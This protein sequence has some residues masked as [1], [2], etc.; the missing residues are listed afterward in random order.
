MVRG[1]RN[2]SRAKEMNQRDLAPVKTLPEHAPEGLG[3][4]S[5]TAIVRGPS[6]VAQLA[7][8]SPVKRFVASSSL[9]P[10]AMGLVTIPILPSPDFDATASF[11]ATLGFV[12]LS[13]GGRRS[14]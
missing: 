3:P 9:A 10:G 1:G 11:Y 14:T 7:E 2:G 13:P 8:R 4:H 5:V 6:G 12:E